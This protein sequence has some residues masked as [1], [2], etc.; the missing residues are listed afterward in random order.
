MAVAASLSP[1]QVDGP[2]LLVPRRIEICG[3]E[4]ARRAGQ[5]RMVDRFPVHSF[6]S[7]G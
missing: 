1:M 3:I 2:H 5:G 6:S 4:A 7:S